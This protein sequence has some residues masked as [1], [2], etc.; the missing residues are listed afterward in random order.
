VARRG[1]K[2]VRS[3]LST[4]SAAAQPATER[5]ARLIGRS[6]TVA[7]QNRKRVLDEPITDRLVSF[8]D[9]DARPVRRGK[10]AQPTQFGYVSQ[11][12]ELTGS[13]KGARGVI[14]PPVTRAGSV[15]ENALL[16]ETVDELRRPGL[17]PTE[18]VFD[19]G[20]G[21]S[22]TR[23]AL[24][25]LGSDIFIVGSPTNSGSRRTRRRLARYRVGAEGGIAHLE[26][27]Y[28]AGRSRLR[29]AQ[30]AA[31]WENWAVL[32]YNLDTAAAIPLRRHRCARLRD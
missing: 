29:G 10:I 11:I 30:G 6:T 27:T 7:G 4:W 20:F 1:L 5:L 18:A 28:R 17:R 3:K 13:T 14:L 25:E 2:W 21:V 24:A 32:A 31:I 15:P 8:A 9:P 22:A 12:A 16:P 26:R 19:A 23:E